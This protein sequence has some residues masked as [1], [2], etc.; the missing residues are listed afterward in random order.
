MVNVAS[1]AG[2]L[3]QV[4]DTPYTATKHA[5][6]ALA[7]SLAITYGDRGVQRWRRLPAVRRD[8]DDRSRR[9]G[10]RPVASPG[11]L[12]VDQAASC[13]RDGIE[14]RPLPD[15]DAPGGAG[16]CSARLTDHER[17][18]V[19][20]VASAK[21]SAVAGSSRSSPDVTCP[22]SQNAPRRDLSGQRFRRGSIRNHR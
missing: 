12:P 2:L 13:D 22:V 9:S 21:A 5:A 16:F 18:L 19:A 14:Q 17:W 11:V 10:R 15:P 4:G 8:G 3:S 1:A 7:E 6:V 20:C